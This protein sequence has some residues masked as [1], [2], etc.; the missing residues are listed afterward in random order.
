MYQSLSIYSSIN[1][2]LPVDY[3]IY[4]TEIVRLSI[5][6]VRGS[7]M[8]IKEIFIFDK[9]KSLRVP[10][11]LHKVVNFNKTRLG[12]LIHSAVDKSYDP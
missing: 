7:A 6:N 11:T 9:W 12:I 1:N 8:I 5:F 10:S 4:P 2:L 3:R